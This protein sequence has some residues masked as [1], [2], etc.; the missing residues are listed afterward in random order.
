MLGRLGVE[1][2]YENESVL[3]DLFFSVKNQQN[4]TIDTL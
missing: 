1:G 4:M 2:F 3:E